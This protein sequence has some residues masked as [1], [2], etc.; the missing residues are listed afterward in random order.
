MPKEWESD[1]IIWLVFIFPNDCFTIVCKSISW[2]QYH[3]VKASSR[4]KFDF[5]ALSLLIIKGGSQWIKG[6]FEGKA[7]EVDQSYQ[8]RFHS[9]R[10][11]SF[12]IARKLTEALSSTDYHDSYFILIRNHLLRLSSRARCLYKWGPHTFVSPFS[13]P[14]NSNRLWG[15]TSQ[16]HHWSD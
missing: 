5:S 1:N 10:S 2:K 9:F 13:W 7:L 6:D 4:L 3:L 16:K 12:A 8:L 11:S 15:R 14:V